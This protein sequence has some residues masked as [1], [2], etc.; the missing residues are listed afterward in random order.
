MIEYAWIKNRGSLRERFCKGD[1]TYAQI[2]KIMATSCP[3][4]ML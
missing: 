4:M 1:A 3:I 2:M